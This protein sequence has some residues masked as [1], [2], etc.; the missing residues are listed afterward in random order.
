MIED[1]AE[2]GHERETSNCLA[3]FRNYMDTKHKLNLEARD[4]NLEESLLDDPV[5]IFPS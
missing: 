3:S 1:A 2:A 5:V 4:L